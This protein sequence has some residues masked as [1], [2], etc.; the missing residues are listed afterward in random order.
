M[1]GYYFITDA[2]LSRRGNFSDVRGALAAGVKYIQYRDKYFDRKKSYLEARRLRKICKNAFFLVNDRVDIALSVGADGVHLGDDDLP[3]SI[4]RKLLGRKKIIGLTVHNLKEAQEAE[5]L[6]A[7]YLGV[8]PIFLTNTKLDAGAPAGIRLI[9]QIKEQIA[10]PIVAIGG[11][12]LSNAKEVIRAGA[13]GLSAI[14]AVVAKRNV[15][16]EIEKFQEL[17]KEKNDN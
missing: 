3:Y 15:K 9:K 13:D 4:A 7:D 10:L 11:I 17:F 12:N 6:G 1:I 14:S 8:S 16:K 5:K 2:S